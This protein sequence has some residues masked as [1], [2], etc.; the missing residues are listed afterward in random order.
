M[1]AVT[2]DWH[3]RV[4]VIDPRT[5]KIVWQ[6]GHFGIASA[7]RGY[8]SK[9]EGLDLLPAPFAARRASTSRGST[10]STRTMTTSGASGVPSATV[11]GSPATGASPA[12]LCV[13]RVGTLPSPVSRIA[14]AAITGGRI[15]ALGGLVGGSS[16]DQVLLGAPSRLRTVAHLPVPT[17]DAAAAPFRG[18]IDLFGGGE[19]TSVS[20][21]VRVD[22]RIGSARVAAHLDEPLSDLGATTVGGHPPCAASRRARQR[23]RHRR[24]PPDR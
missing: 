3:H 4:I 24:A 17:H 22:P 10:A 7:A 9:P 1:I 15:L 21:V 13:R 5:K 19:S 11:A 8:L 6:Y 20:T 16:S 14:A 2:D 23:Y 12:A 18:A